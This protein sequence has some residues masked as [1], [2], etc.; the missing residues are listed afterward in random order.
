MICDITE[1]TLIVLLNLQ[2]I[3]DE[4][5]WEVIAQSKAKEEIITKQ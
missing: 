2:D 3:S 5:V 1:V 4:S